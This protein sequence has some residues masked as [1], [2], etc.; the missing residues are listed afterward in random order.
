[1]RE[2]KENTSAKAADVLGTQ[3]V[4][5]RFIPFPYEGMGGWCANWRSLARELK[6]VGVGTDG[7]WCGN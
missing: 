7:G 4:M 3:P 5:L 1:M 2:T 6:E